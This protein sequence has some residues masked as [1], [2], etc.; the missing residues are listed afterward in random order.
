MPKTL[1]EH[2]EDGTLGPLRTRAQAE[3]EE[4]LLA[5][6]AE[7]EEQVARAHRVEKRLRA[8]LTKIEKLATESHTEDPDN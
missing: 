3:R 8:Y 5:R 7:L 4:E 6:V 1:R 2:L